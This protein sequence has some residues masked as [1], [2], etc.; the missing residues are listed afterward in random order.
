MP[1]T[2]SSSPFTLKWV[3]GTRV[4]RCYGCNGEIKNPPESIPDD[5]I[6]VYR[7]RR[8]FRERLTG[9]LQFTSEPQNIHFHLRAACISE[10]DT[11]ASLTLVLLSYLA[12]FGH[13]FT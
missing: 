6:V 1:P 13:I 10:Q 3:A 5:L 2:T 8:Q 11:P 9:Q 7:D 12:I 4:S